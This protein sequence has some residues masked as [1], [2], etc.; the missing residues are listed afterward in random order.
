MNYKETL[1][2]PKTDFP[3]KAD[4]PKREPLIQ[5]AWRDMDVYKKMVEA[6]RDAP[7]FILHDGPPYANGDIHLGT[8]LNKILKDIIIKYRTMQGFLAPYVPGWD[9]HGLP[10]EHEVE[11]RMDQ[12]RGQLDIMDI[13][14][15]CHEYA[16]RFVERQSGQFQRLGV[17]GDFANPYLTLQPAYEA[18]TIRMFA[19]LYEKGLIYRGLK[20]I[21]WCSNCMTALAEAEIEYAEK[22]SSSI[23]VKF[24]V[25]EGLEGVPAGAGDVSMVIWTTTPWTL[26]ANVAIALHPEM[27]YALVKVGDEALIIGETLLVNVMQDLGIEKYEKLRTYR[28]RDLV[29]ILTRHPWE[30]RPTRV[31]SAEYVDF[32]V[33]TGAVHIAPGHGYEDYQ[34]GLE[35]DL[36]MPMPV[37]D[38][39][40]FTSEA[41]LFAGQFIQDANLSILDDLEKRGLLLAMREVTHPYPHCWRCKKPVIFRATPQWFIAVDL[42]YG[43]K[44]L[45]ERAVESLDRVEWIPGWNYKRILGML[46]MRPDWCISRQRSWGV[47]IPVFYCDD[48]GTEVVNAD[49]L[50]R[51]AKLI[52][53][54]G[55][56]SW[57]LLTPGEMLGESGTC[58]KCGSGSL[59][60]GTDILDV[61]FESGIS[62]EAVLRQWDS[63]TWPSDMYLEGSDQH[64]GW[65]Q[66]SLLT[67]IGTS[68]KPPFR[69][70]LTHGFVVDGDGRKMSKSLG[71]VISPQ[72][73]CDR[74]GADVLRLWVAAADYTVDIPASDE[75]FERLVEA[76][77]RIRNTIRFL[78]GNLYDY[79]DDTHAPARE[80]MEEID[81]WMLS[82]LQ[83][84]VER[85]NQSYDSHQFHQV[86]QAL[87]HF[88]AVD[89]SS[90]YLD[91]RKDCLYTCASDSAARRSAQAVLHRIL[92]VLV[93]IM[94]PILSHTAEETWRSMRGEGGEES[95]FLL[96]WPQPDPDLKNETLEADWAELIALRDKVTK[97]L[98]EMRAGK[99]I[100]TSLEAEVVL[101]VPASEADGWKERLPLLPTLFITSSVIIE[102]VAGLEEVAVE[103]HPA[104]GEKCQRCWNRRA[105]VGSDPGHP[106][107]CDRCIPVVDAIKGAAE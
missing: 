75:I 74:L 107:L 53:E 88:C 96:D 95:V 51:I 57:F 14:R 91:M 79:D 5:G 99:E 24:P 20:P 49:S 47:P 1:N 25:L 33:G 80:E 87:H 19:R 12:E 35:F 8:A 68:E 106:E 28:G 11:K 65:F 17:L 56:D 52:G 62:H 61:W 32:E 30:E 15:R 34:V 93:R 9:C 66:T 4:L 7:S 101:K 23:Y 76:Y 70:V 21:H 82:R 55:S 29:G 54:R 97:R 89:L 77:R 102:E 31:V 41:P 13:R 43:G 71:N 36:P 45:R 42:A 72:D 84:F 37:D 100:G 46:E 16:M 83:S 86:Y 78:L 59:R 40:K 38:E 60:K 98:E 26:P 67:A 103:A 105:S 69:K 64:R 18:T 3:M 50:R 81:L 92:Q 90:L 22:T 6:R 94:S 58:G 10:T 48:C 39:G 63:L 104:T 2:L 85:V 73:I 44:S 27:E